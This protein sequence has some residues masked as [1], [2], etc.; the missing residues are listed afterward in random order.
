MI[1]LFRSPVS[2]LVSIPTL[3]E[4]RSNGCLAQIWQVGHATPQRAYSV[5]EKWQISFVIVV[6]PVQ[7]DMQLCVHREGERDSMS[8]LPLN[9]I[10]ASSW[11][12]LGLI[13]ARRDAASTAAGSEKDVLIFVV[14][15]V[16]LC[17]LKFVGG[18]YVN[19]NSV[20]LA[21]RKLNH[22]S[23]GKNTLPLRW[24]QHV[25]KEKPHKQNRVGCAFDLYSYQSATVYSILWGKSRVDL[26][27]GDDLASHNLARLS[28]SF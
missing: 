7:V 20:C 24:K 16:S 4:N 10:T 27:N 18:V 8:R 15:Y 14:R 3:V 13:S 11:S 19:G 1:H 6:V 12:F 25:V 28:V 17:L 26:H 2:P 21:F 23:K 9:P 22:D 5:T